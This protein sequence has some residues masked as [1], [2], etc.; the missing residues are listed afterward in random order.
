[1][2]DAISILEDAFSE[3]AQKRVIMPTRTPIRNEE[4]D[5]VSLFMPAFIPK[6]G[7]LGAKIVTVYPNNPSKHNLPAVMGLLILIEA[8]TGRPICVMDAGY[9]TAVRTG[10]VSGLATKYLAR[11][12]S[13]IHT[14]FG[15]GVQARTQA[16]AV[17]TARKLEKCICYSIDPHEKKQAF[18]QEVEKLTNVPTVVADDPR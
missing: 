2:A 10:A 4:A 17:A 3:L 9:L 16:W 13:K 5:G 11:Q 15:T 7:A 14:I 1:M 8:E 6:M 12:D 18:A